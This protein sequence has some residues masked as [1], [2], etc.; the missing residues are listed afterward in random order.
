MTAMPTRVI[1]PH[2]AV[3]VAR[4]WFLEGR[5]VDMRELATVLAVGRAT[6]YRVVGSRDRLLGDVV[7]SLGQA[8][9]AAS[10]ATAVRAGLAPGVERIVGAATLMNQAIVGF[11]PLRTFATAEPETA[12]RVLF[13][14]AARVHARAVEGWRRVLAEAA[15]AG[16]LRLRADPGRVAYMWVRIGESVIYADLLA[17]RE[18]DLEL[19]VTLQRALLEA[20][21]G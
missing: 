10:V 20:G 3:A 15:A 14:P 9:L 21:P 1:E 5:A 18:P 11:G 13:M 4:S 19:A 12:F 6:L 17:D 7:D 2:D 16:E 8:T